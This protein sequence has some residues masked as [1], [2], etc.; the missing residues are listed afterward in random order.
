MELPVLVVNHTNNS[1]DSWQSTHTGISHV[2]ESLFFAFSALTLLVERQ[3]E[4]HLACKK[5]SDGVLERLFVWSEVQMICI[6]SS[7]CHCYPIISCSSKIQN[8][9][10]S[11]AG[12]PRL[13]WKR[14]L[15]R[16]SS[17]GS[18]VVVLE[19]LLS[20]FCW[21]ETSVQVLETHCWMTC[22]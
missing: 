16:C 6:W 8:G 5:L 15:N 1:F 20:C 11:G 13:S 18:W 9:L 19:L 7:W 2:L 12:L 21:L 4:G 10:F 3:E 22:L 14:P 17:S